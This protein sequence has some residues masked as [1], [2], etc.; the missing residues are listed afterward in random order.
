LAGETGDPVLVI[1]A[2]LGKGLLDAAADRHLEALAE[3]DAVERALEG[4]GQVPG[5]RHGQLVM[6]RSR[7][8]T[9]VGKGPEAVAYAE[10]GRARAASRRC[11]RR[12]CS[13]TCARWLRPSPCRDT[14]NARR[15][16]SKKR[17]PCKAWTSSRQPNG[18]RCTPAWR[19]RPSGG[20]TWK[21]RW[22]GRRKHWRW[23]AGCTFRTIPR[24]PRCWTWTASSC[25]TSPG[26]DRRSGVEG[27]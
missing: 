4:L 22:S 18:S 2:R 24:A 27:Q 21:R 5:D 15:L 7:A 23:L 1:H 10:A 20:G 3:F 16:C 17:L 14:S 25:P 26:P 11:R 12:R 6:H 9:D 13:S 19:A 8:L